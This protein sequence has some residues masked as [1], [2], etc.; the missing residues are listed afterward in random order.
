M[1]RFVFSLLVAVSSSAQPAQLPRVFV[2]PPGPT[3][4]TPVTVDVYASCGPLTHTVERRDPIIAIHVTPGGVCD[5]PSPLRHPVDIGVL[6]AGGYHIY[7]IVDGWDIVTVQPLIVRNAAEGAFAV[8]P[9][10]VPEHPDGL[11]LRIDPRGLPAVTKVVVGGVTIA[12][13]DIT[14]DGDAY[15]FPAP[16]HAPGL[17]DVTIETADGASHTRQGAVYYYER[18]RPAPPSVFERVLFP[19]LSRG[20]GA[21]G[22]QWVSEA[23]IGNPAPWAIQAY[24][25]VLP[26]SP[27]VDCGAGQLFDPEDTQRFDGAGYPGGIALLVPREEADALAFSLRVRDTSRAAEGYGTQVPVLR[28]KDLFRGTDLTLLDVPVD[29]TVRTKLRIYAFDTSDRDAQVTVHRTSAPDVAVARYSVPMRRPACTDEC[30]AIP[31]Y[32][33]LDLPDDG[34]DGGRNVYIAL[35]QPPHALA[36]AFASITNNDTQQVTIVTAD[37]NGGRP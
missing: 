20:A 16:P 21:H 8:R 27:C 1:A 2:D 14:C 22:S 31:W 5:S 18:G 29:P 33:E 15:S 24:N 13:Q 4:A 11:P 35:G 3:S 28:E 6:P 26:L 34:S 12:P 30:D 36:W 37:G 23:A 32:G 7:L 9:F 19:V 25:D 17:A 10:A